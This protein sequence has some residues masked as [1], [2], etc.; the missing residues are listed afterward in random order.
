MGRLTLW[1]IMCLDDP[2]L[3]KLIANELSD[4][5]RGDAQAHLAACPLCRARCDE[6]RATWDVLGE[7]DVPEPAHSLAPAVLQA[8]RGRNWTWTPMRLAAAI[9]LAAGTGA[10]LA[11]NVPRQPAPP[12]VSA[13]TVAPDQVVQALGLDALGSQP[14]LG[15]VFAETQEDL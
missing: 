11:L 9:A 1:S 10:L 13:R 3:I 7:W 12:V 2:I 6:L 4:A 15:D 14:A 8:A 5:Q